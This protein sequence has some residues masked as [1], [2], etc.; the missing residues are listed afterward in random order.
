MYGCGESNQNHS[1]N[2]KD[3]ATHNDSENS[4]NNE[5]NSLSAQQQYEQ[6]ILE[7]PDHVYDFLRQK[8]NSSGKQSICSSFKNR[9]VEV[10]LTVKDTFIIESS[11]KIYEFDRQGNLASY[12]DGAENLVNFFK[13]IDAR[14]F[15]FIDSY[16]Q[17]YYDFRINID[18]L[19]KEIKD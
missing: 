15:D 6:V 17:S 9:T 14:E 16:N 11:G 3:T 2:N 7:A 12:N 13:Q 5:G 19:C 8:I 4:I 1:T 18:K 10:S